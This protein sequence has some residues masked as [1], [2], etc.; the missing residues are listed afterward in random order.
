MSKFLRETVEIYGM[1]SYGEYKGLL[2]E[3]IYQIHGPF[4]S[5]MNCKLNIPEFSLRACSP[6]STSKQIE[7]A[8]KFSGDSG[9]VL[10]LDNPRGLD[11][12]EYLRAFNC[13][14]ISRFKEED[15][16]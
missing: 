8:M 11:Q 14:W 6:T 10:T 2:E 4:F 16:R 13:S 1:C 12:Y 5:G 7:V 9:I 15:E 3:N